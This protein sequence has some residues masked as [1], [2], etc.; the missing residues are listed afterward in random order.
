MKT[1][2]S[3]ANIEPLESRI[4][5]AVIIV[6]T[7][8]DSG[9]GSLRAA[10]LQANADATVSA[11][12]TII[13]QAMSHG[14]AVPLHG[15]ITLKS[16]LPA[17]DMG[18]GDSLTITGPTAGKSNGIT[19]NGNKHQIF[20]I[21]SGAV[22]MTDLTVTHGQAQ[23]G[24]GMYIN[25]SAAVQLTDVNITRNHA[26]STTGA[27]TGYGGGIY[28]SSTSTNV[29]ISNSS[30]N[31]NT[32]TGVAG[33]SSAGAGDA[34]GGGILCKGTLVLDQSSVSGNIAQG[35][36]A[37]S[38]SNS[39]NGGGAYGGGIYASKSEAN[40]TIQN[41]VISGNK[42]IGGNGGNGASGEDG[43]SGAYG[44][45]GGVYS[46]TGTVSISDTTISK[47]SAKSGKGGN[48]AH[49]DDGGKSSDS[50]GGGVSSKSTNA[51][52]TITDSTISGNS[53]AAQG[54]GSKGAGGENGSAGE[55]FGGGV[56]SS[57]TLSVS[58][59]TITGNSAQFGAGFS[60]YG[61]TNSIVACAITKN[62]GM[63]GGGLQIAKGTVTVQDSTIAQNGGAGNGGGFLISGGTVHIHNDTI[64][65][66][67][68]GG[69]KGFGGGLDVT[70]TSVVDIIS[71]IIAEN[72]A[73]HDGDM[74]AVTGDVSASYDLIQ[75]VTVDTLYIDNG[76][77]ITGANP[78]LGKLGL[79][80]GGTTVTLV[81]AANSP[82]IGKGSNPDSLGMDQNGNDREGGDSLVDIGA[83]EVA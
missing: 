73:K 15:T 27:G 2:D 33:T 55:T 30:I 47:N 74:D 45:G 7:T 32:A 26:V 41:S 44:N 12:D 4:A 71:T 6:S 13:F 78:L 67:K 46:W 28:I 72:T 31:G 18:A 52:L 83:V 21:T 8:A 22:T 39:R 35:G 56:Y 50:W 68:A 20:S 25:D 24:G 54:G 16:D 19:I 11:A 61:G 38:G 62:N 1:I 5:P 82:V 80:D 64:A 10:I 17:I 53:V 66:N 70:G 65:E 36:N 58:Q 48:G 79:H 59:S 63:N 23:Y 42:V 40:V 81:P 29:T 76:N 75:L 69:A 9:P 37:K 43:G 49:G 14:H 51:S 3:F 57:E 34:Y 77:N 60:I